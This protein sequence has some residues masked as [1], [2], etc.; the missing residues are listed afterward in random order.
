MVGTRKTLLDENHPIYGPAIPLF[1]EKYGDNLEADFK[2][3][4]LFRSVDNEIVYAE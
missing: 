2:N 3:E 1:L 4:K